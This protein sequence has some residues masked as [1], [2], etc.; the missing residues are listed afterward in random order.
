MTQAERDAEAVRIFA[1]NLSQSIPGPTP[2]LRVHPG[3]ERP[4][5]IEW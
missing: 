4:D 3:D 1:L 5:G 2:P